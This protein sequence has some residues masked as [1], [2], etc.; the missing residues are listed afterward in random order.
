VKDEE[1]AMRRLVIA[2]T[3]AAAVSA[4]GCFWAT[5]KSE[6]KALRRDVDAL[7]AR[8]AKKEESLDGKLEQLKGIL[9]EATKLL[10]RNSAGLGADVQAMQDQQRVLTGLVT[11]AKTYA[12]EIKASVDKLRG[13]HDD[14]LATLETRVAALEGKASTPSN[15]EDLWNT[16]KAAFE[17]GRQDEARELFKRLAVQFPQHERAD[18]AQYFRAESYYAQKD[19]EA[20]I[21]EYQKVFDKY[22]DSSLADDAL[23][24]AGEAAQTL[25]NCTEARAYFGLLR[26]KYA[27]SNLLKKAGDKDKELKADAKNKAKCNP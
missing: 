5:T 13:E 6:G 12:D 23:Y 9:D 15:P 14:R 2:A 8:V 18:D 7:D 19:Y 26:Q 21:R 20:A 3:L 27:K 11:A 4:P 22:P 1:Y 17:A 25:K 16:G 10:K 24:R